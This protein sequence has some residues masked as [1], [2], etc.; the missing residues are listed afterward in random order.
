MS[1]TPCSESGFETITVTATGTVITGITEDT[2]TRRWNTATI[3]C[4][5]TN[6]RL[7]RL[8]RPLRRLHRHAGPHRRRTIRNPDRT[9][10]DVPAV[11]D[12]EAPVRAR[13]LDK[14]RFAGS[15]EHG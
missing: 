8:V 3:G 5:A 15:Y 2:G 7:R 11:G 13:V 12:R 10:A 4:R 9:T 6:R 1:E 14:R